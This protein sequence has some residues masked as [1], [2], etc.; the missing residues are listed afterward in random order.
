MSVLATDALGNPTTSRPPILFDINRDGYVD[1]LAEVWDSSDPLGNPLKHM[2]IL[3]NQGRKNQN[4]SS[5]PMLRVEST[6]VM[7]GFRADYD[8]NGTID[9]CGPHG[10]LSADKVGPILSSWHDFAGGIDIEHAQVIAM[11]DMDG[12]KD[13]DILYFDSYTGIVYLVRNQLR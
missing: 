8:G 7:A 2:R 5:W 6:D 13:A 3:W 12:D 9:L 1:I 11:D 10:Y 4:I